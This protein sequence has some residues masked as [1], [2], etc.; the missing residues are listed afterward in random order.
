MSTYVFVSGTFHGG[1]CWQRVT[2]YLSSEGHDAYTPTL[3]GVGE[4]VHLA[5]PDVNFETHVQDIINVLEFEDMH[6]VV[7]VGH[8]YGGLVIGA[9]ASRVPDRVAQLIYVDGM[10]PSDGK[11]SFDVMEDRGLS[12][13]VGMIR[14]RTAQS[15]GGWLQPPPEQIGWLIAR[16]GVVDE[17]DAAWVANRLTTHPIGTH[18]QAV[19][20]DEDIFESTPR[21]FIMCTPARPRAITS[22]FGEEVRNDPSWQFR[23]IEASHDVMVTEP[24]A[25]AELLIQLT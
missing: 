21:A 10:I 9:V 15:P 7:L 14:E 13:I 1:W 12:D 11:S 5:T 4:R 8:S 18:T 6:N 23:E 25:L 17:E 19:R 24:E 3:T 20:L 22:I 16:G 2:P